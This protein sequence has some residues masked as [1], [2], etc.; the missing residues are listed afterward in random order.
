LPTIGDPPPPEDWAKRLDACEAHL[1]SHHRL[2][3]AG[4]LIGATMH[5]VNN[6]VEALTNYLYLAKD[7]LNAPAACLSYLE[8]AGEELC[9]VGEITS[10]SLS[11]VRADIKVKDID[12]VELANTALQLHRD[13]I[14]GKK[15]NVELRMADSA[16]A[17]GKQGELLQVLVN[18]LH[19]AIDAIPH[20]GTL[21][22]R[23][24]ARRN[25][26]ILTVADSGSGIPEPFRDS[27]FQSFKSSKEAG[28]GL[29]LWVVK[30]I[31]DGHKGK[32]RYRS[33][34]LDRK[35]GTVFRIALPIRTKSER[36]IMVS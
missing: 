4:T 25:E 5:E 20:S 19:N 6:R 11:F 26:A 7:S 3:L 23:V 16:V 34:T 9:R 31:V 36:T 33:R 28:T 15:I 32:I 29:G 17:P 10:R 30:Q 8:S 22:L 2:A 1:R 21:H 24:A 18:L 14:A 13:K 12:L 35:S 27:L